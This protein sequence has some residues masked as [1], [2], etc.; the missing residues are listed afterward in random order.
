MNTEIGHQVLT[1]DCFYHGIIEYIDNP[2]FAELIK[3]CSHYRKNITNYIK[4]KTKL[5]INKRLH[6]IFEDRTEQFKQIIEETGAIISGSFVLQ[7][8]LN[9]KWKGD[10]DIYTSINKNDYKNSDNKFVD[11]FSYTILDIFLAEIMDRNI[12]VSGYWNT[13]HHKVKCVRTFENSKKVKIHVIQLDIENYNEL[14]DLIKYNYDY[15]IYK[16]IYYIEDLKDNISIYA[17]NKILT[18][19]TYF[20]LCCSWNTSIIRYQKYIEDL[21][22]HMFKSM[23]PTEYL[24]K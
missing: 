20:R 18:K 1:G 7:C 23:P 5:R 12:N 4:T 24:K 21:N 13:L 3:S 22:Y 10:I 2:E 17:L 9:E 11:N 14:Y 15:D 6:D 8:I 16:N 19:E